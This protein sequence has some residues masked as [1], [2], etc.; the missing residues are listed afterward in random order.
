MQSWGWTVDRIRPLVQ[1]YTTGGQFPDPNVYNTEAFTYSVG[2]VPYTVEQGGAVIPTLKP[3]IQ[4]PPTEGPVPIPPP[5][6]GDKPLP[7]DPGPG[8]TPL[9]L[10]FARALYPP[11]A[12]AKGK[13]PSKDG[14]DVVA[15]KRALS[16][17]GNGV[18]SAEGW[19][20]SPPKGFWKW[21]PQGW[22][23]SYS[24]AFSHGGSRGS[25]VAG[26]QQGL[27]MQPTGWYGKA[28]HEALVGYLIPQGFQHAGEWAFDAQ[29]VSL[30][31]EALP[32]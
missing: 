20:A 27:P 22:D 3:S 30:Y 11:D 21:D 5:D 25:G 16:R 9:D 4:R 17:A 2:V 29:A 12:A 15:L 1:T 26:F 7:P 24:N 19:K 14:P 31:R 18:G 8:P 32:A 28:T 23:D 13:T 6:G 10:P